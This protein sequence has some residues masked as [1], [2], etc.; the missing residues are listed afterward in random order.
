[1]YIGLQ[2]HSISILYVHRHVTIKRS[3]LIFGE[4]G[5]SNGHTSLYFNRTQY[6]SY[7]GLTNISDS[8]L[9]IFNFIL[10]LCFDLTL[11]IKLNTV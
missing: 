9:V 4:K 7:R 10:I 3:F 2:T 1:M 11:V 5:I 6:K 8:Y